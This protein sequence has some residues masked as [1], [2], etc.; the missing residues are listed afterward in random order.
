LLEKTKEGRNINRHYYSIAEV[1][2]NLRRPVVKKLRDLMR[3]RNRSKAFDGECFC[4]VNGEHLRI[5]RKG[6]EQ[7]AVLEANLLTYQYN[8]IEKEV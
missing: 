3:F 2:E 8:I 4:E 6:V 5:I 1:K 7:E